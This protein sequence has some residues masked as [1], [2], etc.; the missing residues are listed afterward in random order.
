M[1]LR[2]M[3]ILLLGGVTA[4]SQRVDPQKFS[5]YFQPYSA[6]LD[7]QALQTVDAAADFARDHRGLAVAV[8]G[9]SAPPDPDRDVPGLSADRAAAVARVL[10]RVGVEPNRVSMSGNGIVDPKALPTV[11]VRRVDIT[12][13]P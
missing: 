2:W 6:E 7:E 10:A 4:C 1:R 12:V 3:T 11:S 13:G 9:Y 8:T 5:V